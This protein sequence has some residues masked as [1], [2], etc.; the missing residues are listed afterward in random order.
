MWT[1][2]LYIHLPHALKPH[3]VNGKWHRS[4]LSGRYRNLLKRSFRENGVP[5]IYGPAVAKQNPRHKMPKG[6]KH[7]HER[8]LRLAKIKKAIEQNAEVEVKIRQEKMNNRRL[9]GFDKILKQSFP[10]FMHVRKDA[11]AASP[12]A[13]GSGESEISGS[14]GLARKGPKYAEKRKEAEKAKSL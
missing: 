14:L 6:H 5:W 2:L 12:A 3:L 11:G 9:S 10:S 7:V 8:P 1:Q 13:E 4:F